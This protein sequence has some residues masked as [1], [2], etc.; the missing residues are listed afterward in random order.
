MLLLSTHVSLTFELHS[1]KF[2][3]MLPDMINQ[4]MPKTK[5]QQPKG[6]NRYVKVVCRTVQLKF[7]TIEEILSLE[8][9]AIITFKG[10]MD[11]ILQPYFLPM[12]MSK[13]L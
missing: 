5:S 8:P 10:S 1:S 11:S 6:N 7:L 4:P 2:Q 13:K 9:F 3:V 12:C